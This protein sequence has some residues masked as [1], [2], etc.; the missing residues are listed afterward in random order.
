MKYVLA[1]IVLQSIS[2]LLIK[3][4]TFYSGQLISIVI[5]CAVF[6]LIA[7]RSVVWQLAL[8]TQDLAVA[9]PITAFTPVLVLLYGVLILGERL[10]MLNIIG[11]GLMFIGSIFIFVDSRD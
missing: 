3:Y 4:S 1:S 10:S 9:Y 7:L 5:L 6:A 8:K 2:I 11:M